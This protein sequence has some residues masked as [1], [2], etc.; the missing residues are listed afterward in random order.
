MKATKEST[1]ST[2]TARNEK[3]AFVKPI[4]KVIHDL[5]L[6]F[7]INTILIYSILF[8]I[9]DSTIAMVGVIWVG[10]IAWRGGIG[11]GLLSCLTITAS[12]SICFNIPPHNHILIV[13]YFSGKVPG[14]VIGMLQSLI[15][16]LVVGYISTLV[17]KL[18]NEIK[19]RVKTQKELEQKIAE[20][21]A[22]GRTV[23]HDLKNPLMVIHMS[24]HALVEEFKNSDNSKIRKKIDFINDGTQQ[25]I[26]IIESILLLAGIKKVDQKEIKAFP[27]LQTVDEALKRMEYNIEAKNIQISK[28]TEWPQVVGYAPW[29]TEVWMNYISNAIKYGGNLSRQ[30]KPVIEL[31]YDKPANLNNTSSEQIRFWVK[32]NGEGI[33]ND[34]IN[35]LFTEFTRLHSAEH[36]G[37]GLGLSIV[38]TVVNKFGGTVGVESEI[39]KG[40]LFYFTL[41]V[42]KHLLN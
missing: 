7:L 9:P 36:E 31:G 12:F 30:V 41:P 38:K 28:P 33:A 5:E 3:W 11:A 39:G 8:V 22:F 16:G 27:V 4:R 23:A 25:M 21:D 37:H 24:T 6:S 17:H 14:I 15:S 26:N 10:L 40:S 1:V 42:T 13:Y 2:S 32:D 19:L 35:T 18:R 29:I 34:K 20:L